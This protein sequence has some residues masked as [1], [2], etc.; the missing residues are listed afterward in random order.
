MK[1][2]R[3]GVFFLGLSIFTL[4]ESLRAGL[5]TLREP[6]SGFISF[7]AGAVL[8]ALSLAIVFQGWR[9]REPREGHARRTLLAMFAL[10][11]FSLLLDILGFFIATFLL[12][13]SLL[14]IGE[15]RKWWLQAGIS[16]LVV[17]LVYVVFG[18]W[19][20]LPFP[21]GLLKI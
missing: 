17:F 10:L 15:S 21:E 20:Q 11:A 7:C 5:G 14:Q 6:G 19:L 9:R 8:A 18:V 4:W 1:T 2:L 3:G 16:A 13:A 12:V